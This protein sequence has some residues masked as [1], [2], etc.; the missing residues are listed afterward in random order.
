LS[1]SKKKPVRWSAAWEEARILIWSRRR[2]LSFGLSLML[3]NRLAGLVLP[4]L[5]K[6]VIDD[7][8]GQ[9]NVDLLPKLV[10]AVGAATVVQAVTSFGL[11]QVL[12]VAAQKAINWHSP[13]PEHPDRFWP[14]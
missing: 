12:G 6:Q 5:S 2:R 10:W 4:L 8:I 14:R 3:V 9:G 1:D 13:S 11:S 7:V